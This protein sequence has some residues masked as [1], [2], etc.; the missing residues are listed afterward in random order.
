M[1]RTFRVGDR[2]RI[3]QWDDM[4]QEFGINDF[5][6]ISTPLVFTSEMR[7]YCGEEGVI[8]SFS[9][10]DGWPAV[11]F[12][13]GSRLATTNWSFDTGMIELVG[14]SEIRV[15][16]LVRVRSWK[17]MAKKYGVTSGGDIAT[18]GI[19]FVSRM[20]GACGLI[21]RVVQ[22]SMFF[23]G[24]YTYELQGNPVLDRALQGP[25]ARYKLTKEMIKKE[26][27]L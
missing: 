8:S 19:S 3:R 4:A 20:K 5:N 11:C 15:G 16:D 21:G 7:Q 24:I 12:E 26:R 1:P 25:L 9:S 6:N 2:V 10:E 14:D 27:E 17:E 22:I 13:P 18:P 23:S